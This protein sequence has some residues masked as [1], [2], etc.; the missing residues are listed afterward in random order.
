[1]VTMSLCEK[2]EDQ[3]WLQSKVNSLYGCSTYPT[4]LVTTLYTPMPFE[5]ME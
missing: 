1:M 3:L 4:E 5:R 2:C